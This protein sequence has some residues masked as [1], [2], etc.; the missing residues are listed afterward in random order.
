MAI[1]LFGAAS[2]PTDGAAATNTTDPTVLTPPSSMV[3]GQL[4]IVYGSKRVASG[5]ISMSNAGGQT[6]TQI[7]STHN[8]STA[9]LSAA[10]FWCTFNG[11]WSANPSVSFSSTTCNIAVMLVFSPNTV[12]NIWNYSA[13]QNLSSFASGSATPS[14]NGGSGGLFTPPN[15]TAIN[16][17]VAMTDDD[18]TYTIQAPANGW[19]NTGLSAQYR[20]TSGTDA[21]MAFL[22]QATSNNTLLGNG[23]YSLATNG[24]DGGIWGIWSFYE[25]SPPVTNNSGFFG[26]MGGM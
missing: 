10:A 9:T 13:S 6:W 8:G 17:Y 19:S 21:S 4:V 25:T 7:G 12:G 20:N 23:N 5:A 26:L 1:T 24:P 15:A 11:T 18:N 2:T 16:V 3:A 22:Y 14:T